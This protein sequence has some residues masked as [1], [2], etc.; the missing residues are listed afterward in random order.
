M[1]CPYCLDNVTFELG[2]MAPPHAARTSAG[3]DGESAIDRSNNAAAGVNRYRCPSCREIVPTMYVLDYNEYPPMVIS[4]VG[5]SGHGKSVYFASLFH[6]LRH[7]ALARAWPEF[8][9]LALD[10]ASLKIALENLTLLN[11]GNLPVATPNNFPRP[12]LLRLENIPMVQNS[13]LVIYDVAGETFEQARNIEK[14]A[15][16]LAKA[17]TVLF[18]ISLPELLADDQDCA[19]ALFQLLNAYIIGVRE[20]GGDTRNQNLVVVFTKADILAKYLS[21][22]EALHAYVARD[23]YTDLRDVFQYL[24][25]VRQISSELE[26]FTAQGIHASQFLA[27]AKGNFRR[28]SFSLISALGASPDEET[29]TLQ[30]A[31][32]PRRVLDPLLM[33]MAA[34]C[35]AYR[36]NDGQ[37]MPTNLF[38]KVR[39]AVAR[40]FV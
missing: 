40:L 22:W 14:Y 36:P 13:T 15:Q 2:H 16:F 26:R 32:S 37:V 4:A 11:R 10:D 27:T 3:Q 35:L 21:D 24:A 6:A 39:Q 25:G 8:Y 28:V 33:L 34:D 12:T 23:P 31:V 20:I 7:E 30:T 38:G 18:L 29:R 19:A 1:L 5:F 9:T 17:G